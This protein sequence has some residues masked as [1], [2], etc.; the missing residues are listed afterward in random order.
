[1]L[2]T[3]NPIRLGRALAEKAAMKACCGPSQKQY[4]F[5]KKGPKDN[6]NALTVENKEL[7]MDENTESYPIKSAA[8]PI[9]EQSGANADYG[10]FG[11]GGGNFSRGGA[12]G[13]YSD[14]GSSGDFIAK[15]AP[16]KSPVGKGAPVT[17]PM[18]KGPPPAPVVPKD[19]GWY[20]NLRNYLGL[21]P[22]T[23]GLATVGT[24]LAAGGLGGY[25][26]AGGFNSKKKKKEAAYHLGQLAARS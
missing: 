3:V 14:S 23:M 25:A 17:P 15:T 21:S 13:D 5:N 24:G 18:G 20:E 16:V 19:L 1:M 9:K 22:S 6:T 7:P 10:D 12:G 2:P 11:G 4:K 26:L 8:K